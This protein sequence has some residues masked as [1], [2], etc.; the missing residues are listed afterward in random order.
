MTPSTTIFRP[1]S[2]TLLAFVL[3]SASAWCGCDG[4]RVISKP[5]RRSRCLKHRTT[6]QP[7]ILLNID[8][9]RHESSHNHPANKADGWRT[10]HFLMSGDIKTPTDTSVHYTTLMSQKLELHKYLMKLS[11]NSLLYT[12]LFIYPFKHQIKSHLLF[13]GIIRGSPYSAC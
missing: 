12:L 13:A 7:Q 6:C 3:P 1:H 5:W 2:L 11:Y 4:W 8:Y 9:I 10:Y